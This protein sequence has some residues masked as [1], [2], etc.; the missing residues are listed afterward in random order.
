[1]F[2][3]ELNPSVG[4]CHY[5]AFL[6]HHQLLWGL[7]NVNISTEKYQRNL[8]NWDYF[9]YSNLSLITFCKFDAYSFKSK[10]FLHSRMSSLNEIKRLKLKTFIFSE[11]LN[12]L[13][14]TVRLRNNKNQPG[15][16]I[17]LCSVLSAKS[18]TKCFLSILTPLLFEWFIIPGEP[19]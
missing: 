7:Y 12:V 5:Q 6:P 16:S 1:M 15:W 17:Y 18:L 11:C 4:D 9:F 3:L 19:F 10:I 14:S 2:K 8:L 13:I